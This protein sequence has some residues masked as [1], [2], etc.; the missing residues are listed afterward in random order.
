MEKF[1]ENA[2]LTL[3]SKSATEE[4]RENTLQK[5]EE[6]A[7]KGDVACEAY[8]AY[9][10]EA[11][12]E[13]QNPYLDKVEKKN[14]APIAMQNGDLAFVLGL[15]YEYGLVK[16]TDIPEMKKWFEKAFEL[17]NRLSYLEL[18][19]Y[20]LEIAE[21]GEESEFEKELEKAKS[22]FNKAGESG[23]SEAYIALAES[24]MEEDELEDAK[25]MYQNAANMGNSNGFIG[26]AIIASEENRKSEIPALLEKALAMKN[27]IAAYHLSGYYY[28]LNDFE[29]SLKYLQTSA[30]MG[31]E[32]AQF[33]LGF[34]YYEGEE[35]KQDYKKALFYFEKAAE[36]DV[37]EAQFY[38]GTMYY[39][40]KGV[41]KDAEQ[42]IYW[43]EEAV[44][45]GSEDAEEYLQNI[46]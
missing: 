29:K 19:Y 9:Y 23:L 28:E 30:D 42:A 41:K 5:L 37:P 33:Q 38:L 15:F 26:L 8:L 44:A 35:L 12:G 3:S 11:V 21:H 40:G 18:G 13:E 4:M 16:D 14:L 17:G 10:Y 22:F 6:S 31:F 36:S 7:K 20:H 24:Y 46:E 43:L 27:S 1:F 39:E 34:V 2:V 32:E 45:N 25:K